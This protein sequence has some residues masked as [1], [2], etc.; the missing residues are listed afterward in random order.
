MKAALLVIDVQNEFFNLSAETA[1]SL[2]DAIEYIN[3]AI[4]SL[5]TKTIQLSNLSTMMKLYREPLFQT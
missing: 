3:E 1:Q 4:H 5:E 2:K